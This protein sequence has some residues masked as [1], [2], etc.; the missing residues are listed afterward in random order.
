MANS[1][2]MAARST[3]PKCPG[4]NRVVGGADLRA[5][6]GSRP[7]TARRRWSPSSGVAIE[8]LFDN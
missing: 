8:Q 4:K 2:A 6:A 3:G 7:S 1:A 5:A